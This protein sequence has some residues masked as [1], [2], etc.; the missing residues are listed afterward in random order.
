[1]KMITGIFASRILH[2][3]TKNMKTIENTYYEGERPLFA[4]HDLGLV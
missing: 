1:M 3:I 2:K 4:E